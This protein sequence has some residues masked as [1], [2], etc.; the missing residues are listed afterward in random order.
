MLAHKSID[1]ESPCASRR[2]PSARLK[3]LLRHF[4]LR[5]DPRQKALGLQDR[6][7]SRR[8]KPVTQEELAEYIGVSRAWY[9]M[10]ESEKPARASIFLLDRL[11]SILMLSARE[12][13]AL[14]ALALPELDFARSGDVQIVA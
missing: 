7:P 4:R 8:G 5:I 2:L 13:A 10:L 14:F 3:A 12:R 1:T 9:C 6:L 11:A